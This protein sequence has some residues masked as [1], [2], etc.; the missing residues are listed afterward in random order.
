MCNSYKVPRRQYYDTDHTENYNSRHN[1]IFNNQVSYDNAL[2]YT[3]LI[4][5]SSIVLFDTIVTCLE[6]LSR[7]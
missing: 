6:F 3:R 7:S 2:L 5:K 1:D 4:R